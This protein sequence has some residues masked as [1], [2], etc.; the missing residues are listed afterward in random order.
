LKEL[1]IKKVAEFVA[2]FRSSS[3]FE[4]IDGM[5]SKR[6]YNLMEPILS[7]LPSKGNGLM[8]AYVDGGSAELIATPNLFVY[9]NKV[10]ATIYRER[11]YVEIMGPYFFI[12]CLGSPEGEDGFVSYIFGAEELLP[13]RLYHKSGHWHILNSVPRRVAE[14]KLALRALE[15]GV[16]GVI[17]DGTLGFQN[18][19]NEFEAVRELIEMADMKEAI[20]AGV[21][22]SSRITYKGLPMVM[23]VAREALKKSMESFIAYIGE[24]VNGPRRSKLFIARLSSRALKPFLIEVNKGRRVDDLIYNLSLSA[25][26]PSIPGYPYPLILADGVAKVHARD[27]LKVMR[28]RLIG[29]LMEMGGSEILLNE[30]FFHEILNSIN[31]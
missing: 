12:S 10:A 16:D 4:E 7:P 31:P 6:G 14:K 11:E 24:V 20:L 25:S 26:D 17:L 28:E 5:I 22:K 18:E 21:A 9:L 2:S 1:D 3:I 27:E 30:S 13:K 23:L 15:G 8:L 19:K 29:G